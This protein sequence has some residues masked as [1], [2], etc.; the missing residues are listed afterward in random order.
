MISTKLKKIQ[1][2]VGIESIVTLKTRTHTPSEEVFMG[3]LRWPTEENARRPHFEYKEEDGTIRMILYFSWIARLRLAKRWKHIHSE[4]P[5]HL[6]IPQSICWNREISV[7]VRVTR[8]GILRDE[9]IES[10]PSFFNDGVIIRTPH[11]EEV[12]ISN[13]ERVL[14]E[15]Q[16]IELAIATSDE[17]NEMT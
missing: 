9:I 6:P 8:K 1:Q 11:D 5:F 2:C 12:T 14:A 7:I 4:I 16:F 13:D 10:L 17:L 3:R 15:A